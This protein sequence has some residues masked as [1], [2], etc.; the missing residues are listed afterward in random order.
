MILRQNP[1]LDLGHP[2]LEQAR[3]GRISD[4]ACLSKST[5]NSSLHANRH[6]IF[7][8]VMRYYQVKPFFLT[9]AIGKQ[10]PPPLYR[11]PPLF[12]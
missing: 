9:D 2:F 8:R 4:T 10:T 7:F 12:Y 5:C 11:Y 3:R 6:T 1:A